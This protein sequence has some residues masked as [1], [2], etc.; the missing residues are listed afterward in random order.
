MERI[1]STANPSTFHSPCGY[2]ASR[3]GQC[4]RQLSTNRYFPDPPGIVLL[5]YI[6]FYQTF[7]RQR[8]NEAPRNPK[9]SNGGRGR[10]IAPEPKRRVNLP[11]VPPGGFLRG[12]QFE[13]ERVVPS[14]SRTTFHTF[15]PEQ[16]SMAPAGSARSQFRTE[17]FCESLLPLQCPVSLLRW[18]MEC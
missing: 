6:R 2:A 11:M 3:R 10:N 1:F 14:L 13:R 12:E 18:K 16:E 9:D 7:N 5:C 17:L 15:L 8:G 4:A